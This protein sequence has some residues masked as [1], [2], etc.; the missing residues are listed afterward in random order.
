[1]NNVIAWLK[2]IS[3]RQILTGLMA[4]VLLFVSTACQ[5]TPSVMAKTSD[6][7]REE[8]PSRNVTSTYEGGMNSYPDTDPRQG[9]ASR[10]ESKGQDLVKN[11][12]GYVKDPNAN[13]GSA[14]KRIFEEAPENAA[15]VGENAQNAAAKLGE[16]A[17]ESANRV[18]EAGESVTERAKENIEEGARSAANK[19][20]NLGDRTQNAAENASEAVKSKVSR[21]VNRAERA[22]ENTAESVKS[23]VNR[24]VN[25]AERAME[26][27]A[28]TV[29]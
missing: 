8:I 22:A 15:K 24:D 2:N 28:D 9:S 19:A 13:P 27:A 18:K 14:V 20:E 10:L 4:G 17:K 1:M 12:E 23:K 25:R 21:D 3:L 5:N 6:Q 26:N 29:K 16:N 7:I 11:A